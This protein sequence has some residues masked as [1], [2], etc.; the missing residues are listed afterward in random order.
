MI[1]NPISSLQVV[2]VTAKKPKCFTPCENNL[3]SW[4]SW[5][6]EQA[7]FMKQ[8]SS[9]Q[10]DWATF[11]LTCLKSILGENCNCSNTDAETIV[12]MILDGLCVMNSN[13][14]LL[15]A[16]VLKEE[17]YTI[18]ILSPWAA[19]SQLPAKALLRG[20][21]VTLQG[22]AT[23][24]GTNN[25]NIF[26]LPAQVAPTQTV[27]FP[28]AHTYNVSGGSDIQIEIDTAGAGKVRTVGSS[29]AGNGTIYLD[30]ISF[31]RN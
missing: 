22:A 11:D 21:H 1:T 3:D 17:V 4:L 9:N 7:C 30:G 18:P 2:D 27:R 15:Q 13:I 14:T 31:F 25:T 5:L 19:M 16:T 28:V 29:P 10:I 23:E 24:G 6:G 26:Q 12:K 8:V 20:K